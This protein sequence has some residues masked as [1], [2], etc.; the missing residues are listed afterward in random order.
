MDFYKKFCMKYLSDYIENYQNYFSELKKDLRQSGMRITLLE[1]LSMTFMT[2]LIFLVLQIPLYSFLFSLT[3][4]NFAFSMFF[5]ILIAIPICIG[6]FLLFL[7]IPKLKIKDK[8]KTIDN[9][10]PFA[11]IYLSTISS[12]KLPPHKIFEI[13]SKFKEHG[14]ISAECSRIV[15]DMQAFGLNIYESLEKAIYRTPSNEFKELLWSMY[16]TLKSGGDLDIYLN[17]KSKSFLDSYRRKL[18]EF[19]QSLSIYLEIYLTALVLGTLFFTILTSLMS[20]M[21]GSTSNLVTLQFLLIFLFI[22]AISASF[23]ILI[24]MSSPG[25]E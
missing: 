12:S 25:G 4:Y 16:S 24:K 3:G 8:R 2:C 21:G 19:S 13:F 17:E 11:G 23:I 15:A 14:E 1:Y 18:N 7:N 6:I 20:G 5:S 10:L 22:P 9:T